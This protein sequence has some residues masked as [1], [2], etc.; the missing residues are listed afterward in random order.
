MPQDPPNVLGAGEGPLL[1]RDGREKEREEEAVLEG[2]VEEGLPRAEIVMEGSLCE[3]DEFGR[4]QRDLDRPVDGVDHVLDRRHR[5]L[6]G[7]GVKVK[8]EGRAV[9]A[10]DDEADV[11]ERR[12]EGVLEQ[13]VRPEEEQIARLERGRRDGTA[14]DR[15]QPV[16]EAPQPDERVHLEQEK[17]ENDALVRG[18]HVMFS[19]W[20]QE[21]KGGRR[22]RSAGCFFSRGGKQSKGAVN[23]M[24]RVFLRPNGAE[25][26]V[27]YDL[28]AF[29]WQ[30]DVPGTTATRV[31]AALEYLASQRRYNTRQM[32][33]QE[34]LLTYT[35]V[36][37][38]LATIPWLEFLEL[39]QQIQEDLMVVFECSICY[40]GFPAYFDDFQPVEGPDHVCLIDAPCNN[41]DHMVCTTCLRRMLLNFYSHPATTATPYLSCVFPDCPSTT[42]MGDAWRNLF[43]A[44]E[45]EQIT[46]HLAKVQTPVTIHTNCMACQDVVVSKLKPEH[47]NNDQVVLEC[48][49]CRTN[50][51]WHC[52]ESQCV[53]LSTPRFY[54][55]KMNRYMN[56]MRNYML[57]DPLIQAQIAKILEGGD[58]TSMVMECPKCGAQVLKSVSCNEMQHCGVKWCYCCGR[59][60][61]ANETVLL[62]HFA[63]ICPRYESRRY[64]HN[65]G[66]SSY[67]CVENVCYTDQKEC[68]IQAHS[69]GRCEKNLH[70][71]LR[72]L[73]CLVNSLPRQFVNSTIEYVK[74]ETE[75][76]AV[77][78]LF[79]EKVRPR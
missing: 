67:C 65:L 28:E 73:C 17:G 44:E 30:F 57:T 3:R 29:E 49:S 10:D 35:V 16:H 38:N 43:T 47:K 37:G 1:L 25:V 76:N 31:G 64:W 2:A 75:T 45:A 41:P 51:C 8:E 19:C 5:D 52:E 48:R 23:P 7:G 56:G 77:A 50:Y 78:A 58:K 20:C 69:I 54:A 21:K 53:C 42:R 74:K 40:E 22:A 27:F 72:W 18:N 13:G 46:A 61:L 36:N 70:L 6:V 55:N 60:T 66:A 34:D 33:R 63:F 71:K 68:T 59:Q 14:R 32:P 39:E 9:F 26:P 24:Q 15:P 62:D 4:R 12:A 11:G 79:M